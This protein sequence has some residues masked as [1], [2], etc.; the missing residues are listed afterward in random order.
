[1]AILAIIDQKIL[2]ELTKVSPSVF[3]AISVCPIPPSSTIA[4]C[5]LSLCW[6]SRPSLL[7]Y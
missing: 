4:M 5:L 1:M 6:C 3:L 7:Y 2:P